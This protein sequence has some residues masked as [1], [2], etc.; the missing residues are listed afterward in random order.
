LPE[1]FWQLLHHGL[2]FRI[3][4]GKPGTDFLQG[5]PAAQA[6]ARPGVVGADFDAGTFHAF[7]YGVFDWETQS[8][9]PDRFKMGSGLNR[10]LTA[11]P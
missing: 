11:L 4:H 7:V 9:Q 8:F 5:A 1:P 10:G 3:A 6:Q 2:A